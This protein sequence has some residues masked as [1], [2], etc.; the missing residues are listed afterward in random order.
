METKVDRGMGCLAVVYIFKKKIFCISVDS[1]LLREERACKSR[2]ITMRI[3]LNKEF[4][5]IFFCLGTFSAF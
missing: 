5:V 3:S 1:C 4:F 2:F